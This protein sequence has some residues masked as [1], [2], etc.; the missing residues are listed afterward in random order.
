MTLPLR[1]FRLWSSNRQALANRTV[2]IHHKTHLC[3]L[4]HSSTALCDFSQHPA[5]ESKSINNLFQLKQGV[6]QYR[7]PNFQLAAFQFDRLQTEIQDKHTKLNH[8]AGLIN[9]LV[10]LNE[11]R[12]VFRFHM[13]RCGILEYQSWHTFGYK[14][15][16]AIDRKRIQMY[17]GQT[18]LII[19]HRHFCRFLIVFIIFDATFYTYWFRLIVNGHWYLII[20]MRTNTFR[21]YDGIIT[22]ERETKQNEILRQKINIVKFKKKTSRI[23][24]LS[25]FSQ[26]SIWFQILLE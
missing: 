20:G 19:D 13:Q 1:Q 23:E 10:A 24:I 26:N 9:C 14:F 22:S 3:A 25:R 16:I 11:Y 17:Y 12:T 8:I 15:I 7:Y 2:A 4:Q 21:C 6:W 18:S 5:T